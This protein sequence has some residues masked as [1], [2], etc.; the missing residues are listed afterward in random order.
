MD[1]TGLGLSCR[2]DVQPVRRTGRSPSSRTPGWEK[3]LKLSMDSVKLSAGANPRTFHPR[4]SEEK[5]LKF[6]G[7]QF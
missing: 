4:G 6:R 1:R 2:K 5:H 7:I 3:I